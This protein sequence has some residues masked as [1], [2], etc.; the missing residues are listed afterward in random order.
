MDDL[1]KIA[2]SPSIGQELERVNTAVIT[3]T[4]HRSIDLW[5][6]VLKSNITILTSH[7]STAGSI[8]QLDFGTVYLSPIFSILLPSRR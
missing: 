8:S 5:Y 6:N 2:N 1:P 7:N 4:M 3:R